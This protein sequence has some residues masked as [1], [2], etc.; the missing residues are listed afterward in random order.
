MIF[1]QLE[2]EF[3]TKAVERARVNYEK[4]KKFFLVSASIGYP[5]LIIGIAFMVSSE[6]ESSMRM[7]GIVSASISYFIIMCNIVY[8][9]MLI[10]ARIK[11]SK[12]KNLNAN[13]PVLEIKEDGNISYKANATAFTIHMDTVNKVDSISLNEA[14]EILSIV[15]KKEG[16]KVE[17]KMNLNLKRKGLIKEILNILVNREAS[18]KYHNEFFKEMLANYRNT[19]SRVMK[20]IETMDFLIAVNYYFDTMAPSGKSLALPEGTLLQY[21]V[22]NIKDKNYLC[23]YTSYQEIPKDYAYKYSVKISYQRA[24][25]IIE[26]VLD[27][28]DEAKL[29]GIVINPYSDKIMID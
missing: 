25:S 21:E 2:E 15:G 24:V 6:E 27:I 26:E 7:V 28:F 14:G 17:I 11:L 20:E 13:S 5:L 22:Q 18:K 4:I 10:D 23:L 3:H 29:D 19:P 1:N 12:S 9:V 16:K 8:L